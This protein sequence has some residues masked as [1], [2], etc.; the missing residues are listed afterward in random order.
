MRWWQQQK[1]DIHTEVAR[2]VSE[3]LENPR[4]KPD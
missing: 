3:E 4:I 1:T 2:L